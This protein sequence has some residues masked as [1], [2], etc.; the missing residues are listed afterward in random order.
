M[1][2]LTCE[3]SP[4]HNN[5]G[6]KRRKKSES[7]YIKIR[8]RSSGFILLTTI[9]VRFRVLRASGKSSSFY[10]QQSL[11]AFE[12]LV[13]VEKVLH[14][15]DNN[16]SLSSTGQLGEWFLYFHFEKRAG[17]EHRPNITFR[18]IL[19]NQLITKACDCAIY[20]SKRRGDNLVAAIATCALR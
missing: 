1:H 13:T 9:I 10:W 15:T 3:K 18:V 20:W 19:I 8:S 12:F 4:F 11:Y 7:Y 6:E 16:L 17:V 14:F 5:R 2:D